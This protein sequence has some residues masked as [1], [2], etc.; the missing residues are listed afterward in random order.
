[1]A[2]SAGGEMLTPLTVVP[3]KNPID[4]LEINIDMKFVYNTKAI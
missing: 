2:A 4:A 3:R 1:M